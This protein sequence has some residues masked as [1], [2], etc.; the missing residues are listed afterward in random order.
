M[1]DLFSKPYLDSSVFFAHIKQE[2]IICPGGLMRW[3]IA[4]HIFEDAE[5]GKYTIFTSTATIAE[6]RR[7]KERMEPLDLAELQQ[8]QEFF[9]RQF[10]QPIDVTRE[11]AEKAQQLGAEHG[12]NP[13]DA[14][15][16]ATAIWWKC[17]VLLVWDKQFSRRFENDPIEGVRVLEP[18]WEGQLE[19]L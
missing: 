17:D 9:Q 5:S 14:I 18:Y 7:I 1:A 15:H 8:I 3:E 12:I 11:I 2:A 16:L 13:I 10:I 19:A 6:V 4:K